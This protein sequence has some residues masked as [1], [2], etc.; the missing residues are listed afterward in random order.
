MP[1]TQASATSADTEYMKRS[2]FESR[3]RP[4]NPSIR[5]L[6]AAI[7]AAAA[8]TVPV[9]AA[10]LGGDRFTLR[11]FG[12]AAV[13]YQGADGLEYRRNIGQGKGLPADELGMYTD[14]VAGL[15]I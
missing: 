9:S 10:D 13:T 3:P 5:T 8:V 1:V 7:C 14:S 15:Q 6:L 12:T 11:G 2:R 4:K